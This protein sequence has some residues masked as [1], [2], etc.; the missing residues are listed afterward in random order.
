MLARRRSA[1]LLRVA[2]HLHRGRPGARHRQRGRTAHL[3]GHGDQ[4]APARRGRRRRSGSGRSTTRPPPQTDDRLRARRPRSRWISRRSSP[5]PA[6]SPASSFECA[7]DPVARRPRSAASAPAPPPTTS[8]SSPGSSP[9]RTRCSCARS[10]RAS[11]ST[12]RRSRCTWTVVGPALT[13][14][15]ADVPL[16]PATT[17]EHERHASPSPPTSPAS[18]SRARSTAPSSRPAPRRSPTPT[19]PSAA[20]PSRSSPPTGSACVEEPPASYEWTIEVP[21]DAPCPRRRSAPAPLDLSTETSAT[22][23][24]FADQFTSGF[25]CALL[26][27]LD[28]GRR[29][30]GP[31]APRRR[32][33]RTSPR[34]TTP[35]RS[36]RWARSGSPTSRRRSTSGRSTRRPRRRST[37]R[38]RGRPLNPIAQ[39]LSVLERAARRPSSARSTSRPS[40]PAPRRR[41]SSTCTGRHAPAP[42]PRRRH[43]R[44]RRPDA[45]RATAGP[46]ARCP[47]PPSSPGPR[48]PPRSTHRDLHLRLEPARRRPSS[49]RSTR[50]SR[51]SSSSRARSPWT[52][53]DLIFGEHELLVRAVDAAGNVDPTPAEYSW[54]IGGV[55]PPV[56]IESGPGPDHRQQERPVRLL[57]RRQRPRLRVLARRRRLLA[58][59]VAARPTTA[60][61]SARTP[62]RSRCS[63]R[64]PL[65]EAPVSTWE[66]TVIDTTGLDTTITHGPPDV[67]AGIDP[68]AGGDATVAFAFASNDPRATFECAIDGE[69]FERVRPARSSPRTCRSATTSSGSARSC[70]TRTTNRQRRPDAGALAV[71]GGRG[72]RDVHRLRARGR[73]R[74]AASREVRLLL[75]RARLDLRV[76]ARLRPV[77]CLLQPVRDRRRARRRR[78]HARGPGE[79]P[80][81]DR[82]HDAGGVELDVD[83]Q[84]ARHDRSSPAPRLSTTST[85]AAFIF[86]SSEPAEFEC[87]LDGGL[88]EGCEE[89]PTPLPGQPQIH[90]MAIELC[91]RPAHAARAGRRRERPLRPDAGQLHLDHRRPRRETTIDS[92]AG[93]P[94]HGDDRVASA[95]PRPTRP[96]PSS[97]RST[98]PPSRPARRRRQYTDLSVGWHRIAVRAIDTAGHVDTSPALHS[99]TVQAP[100]GDD[101][102]GHDDHDGAAGQDREHDRDLP[103]LRQRARHHLRVRA[104][105]PRASRPCAPR[106]TYTELRPRPAH[107]RRCGRPTPPATS[108]WR[109]PSTPGRSSTGDETPPETFIS[110]APPILTTSDSASFNFAATEPSVTFECSLDLSA[111]AACTSPKTY[112]GLAGGD[113]FFYVRARDANGNV[114]PSPAI[115]EWTVEDVTPPDTQLTEVPGQPER[116]APRRASASSAPTTPS[117][118]RARSCGRPSSAAST[119]RATAPGPTAS[120]RRPTPTSAPAR[121]P[122]RCAPSTTRATS[123]RPRRATPGRSS[124]R[125]RRRPRSTPARRR[126]R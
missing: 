6:T 59:P 57:G 72:A 68:E 91:A 124:T 58:V 37:R 109:P 10:T 29:R 111:F 54:E 94:D 4:A 83:R 61:R 28:P 82:R 77:R 113:H 1:H 69:P 8:P 114:D 48:R 104:R 73:G 93:R 7:L 105:Q 52:Y 95:S 106:M 88:F 115:Y 12:R 65:A 117:S 63:P 39:F 32:P 22:F 75:D 78:A 9:A 102:A 107:L 20:T 126:T 15:T 14:I 53:N 116:L 118:S 99:W 51:T 90:H 98:A 121:T 123:T 84:P 2:G 17:T 81:R 125:R 120:A 18:P 49:A 76:R 38:R 24:F 85:S 27:P 71:H 11:T 47:T 44:Q 103:L 89:G 45:G 19:S 92:R 66:W 62:S 46:S 100:A 13:T 79:H 35:S 30:S 87:S 31:R 25:Q 119:A 34:A 36:G 110:S 21:P 108:S 96:R 40:A 55:P 70:S 101:A 74:S 43:L 50:R 86:N 56:M 23:T 67:T 41:S 97:A 60:C 16:E 80:A 5:S 64:T 3:R 112:T 42:R 33:T 122:S 26:D